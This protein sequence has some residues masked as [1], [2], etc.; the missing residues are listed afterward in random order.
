M[1]V[2]G[3]VLLSTECF[4]T[5]NHDE[6]SCQYRYRLSMRTGA[7]ASDQV[8]ETLVASRSAGS[9]ISQSSA[10]GKSPMLAMTESGNDSRRVL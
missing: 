6:E 9:S 10:C 8:K 7:A 3:V 5:R 1:T 2:E 4:P